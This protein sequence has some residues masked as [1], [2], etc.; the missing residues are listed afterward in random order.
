VPIDREAALKKAEKFLR[1]GKLDAAIEEYVRLIDDQP[2]DWNA[3]NALG[4]L[5]LRAG[6]QDRAVAQFA[7]VADHLLAEGFF[8]KAS[9]LYK[10]ALKVQPR[11][12][13]TLSRL[14]DIATRQGLLADAAMY[15]RQLLNERRSRGDEAGVSE[16][17]ARLQALDDE[18]TKPSTA[19]A[20]PAP[21]PP[22]PAV[23]PP[24]PE[25]A[26]DDPA[27]LF[28]L[29]RRQLNAG[30]EQQGRAT[31]TRVLTI[32]PFR[33]A[34]ALQL[35]MDLATA[36]RIETGFG[37]VDVVTDAALLDGDL[38]RAVEALQRFVDAVP[39]VPA[40]LKLVELCVDA[41][42]EDQL[43]AAQ[44]QLAD[45]YLAQGS[46]PEARVI[47]E[48]LL[49]RDPGSDAHA[50]R[51]RRA[52]GLLNVHDA[53]RVIHEVRMRRKT[54]SVE[55]LGADLDTPAEP[56]APSPVKEMAE[57]DLSDAL[58]KITTVPALSGDPAEILQRAMDQMQAGQVEDALAGL[59]EAAAQPR[60][61]ARAAAELGRLYKARGE[62]ATAVQ[63][64]ELAADGPAASQDE[65]FAVLY[66]LADALARL[67]E[68][69]RALAILI[70]LDAEAGEYRDVRVRIEQ[71]AGSRGE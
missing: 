51:L 49:E 52:L 34:E 22:Q 47:A 57:I 35:A 66:D 38:Q 15:L 69:S 19:A 36:G 9:A 18:N 70:D 20:P 45:A 30:D 62:M 7:R 68:P 59:Q 46:G 14:A 42:F 21:P 2:R 41:G 63:W 40:S 28:A 5:Y 61:R 54:P 67:G 4:D 64:F 10:K 37:C 27:Q 50:E 6:D 31:L 60:T 33:H 53:E 65:A 26:P 71:L 58:S 56:P 39:H 55:D 1:Q 43:Q 32:D 23:A 25:P 16:V 13:H 12:E 17:L 44:T 24:A 8:P 48:D 3:I 29:A 11:H